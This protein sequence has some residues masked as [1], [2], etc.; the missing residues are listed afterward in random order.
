MPAFTKID[1]KAVITQQSLGHHRMNAK[2]D[3]AL[4]QSPVVILPAIQKVRDLTDIDELIHRFR[5]HEKRVT[6]CTLFF[7]FWQ[8]DRYGI[9][10][11]WTS[12]A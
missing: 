12:H 1:P 8:G 7:L 10:F 6:G 3:L 4:P 5:K 9:E 2:S 11:I